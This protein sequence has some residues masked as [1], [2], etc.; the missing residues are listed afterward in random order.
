MTSA[1]TFILVGGLRFVPGITTGYDQLGFTGHES[2][3]QLFGLSQVSVLH[4]IVHLLFGIVGLALARTSQGGF[5]FLVGGGMVHL[6]VVA[7]RTDH[8]PRL[9][10]ELRPLNTADNW[11]H[12]DKAENVSETT[13]SA[14][15][16]TRAR[17]V[18]AASWLC[19]GA[20]F[21]GVW[22]AGEVSARQ[23]SSR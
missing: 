17:P 5:V 22:R 3:A 8:R 16:P 21:W 9:W 23:G 10:R 6:T 15:W 18:Q 12:P 4:N 7:V 20:R 19:R 14:S 2:E 11:L 13:T 1:G